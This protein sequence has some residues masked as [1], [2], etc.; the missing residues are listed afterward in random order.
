MK[1]GDTIRIKKHPMQAGKFGTVVEVGH[2][3]HIIDVPGVGRGTYYDDEVETHT[4]P[5]V[6]TERA[7]RTTLAI[8]TD[9][10]RLL[11]PQDVGR[12]IEEAQRAGL[13]EAF[14]F[15]LLTQDLL[16]RTRDVLLTGLYM[17]EKA[18]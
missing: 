13:Q 16:P 3:M 4:A 15:W 5:N 8:T 7:F 6:E 18:F 2:G 14:R 12:A 11:R 9:E 10:P 17:G 1:K